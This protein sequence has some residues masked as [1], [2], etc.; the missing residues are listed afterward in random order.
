MIS[1]FV[2]TAANAVAAIAA[3]LWKLAAVVI[4]VAFRLLITFV[5][6]SIVVPSKHLSSLISFTVI[7][8]TTT[9]EMKS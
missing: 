4:D 6:L 2:T 7:T 1:I 5:I 9:T 8:T 3:I